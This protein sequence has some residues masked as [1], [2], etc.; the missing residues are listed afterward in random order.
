MY[1]IICEYVIKFIKEFYDLFILIRMI[2]YYLN[3]LIV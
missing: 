3:I 2:F 1:M